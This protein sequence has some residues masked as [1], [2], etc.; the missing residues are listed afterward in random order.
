MKFFNH[1][2]GCFFVLFQMSSTSAPVPFQD[3][4]RNKFY[5]DLC[6]DHESSRQQIAEY[7]QSQNIVM[8][9]VVKDA[10]HVDCT[11]TLSNL[12]EM[13]EPFSLFVLYHG[14]WNVAE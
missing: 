4:A 3:A 10:N 2:F 12:Q 11:D 8:L 9:D 7:V 14:G 13:T 1:V 6:I 5:L